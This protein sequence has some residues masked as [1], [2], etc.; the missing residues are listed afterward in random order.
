MKSSKKFMMRVLTAALAL[1]MVAGTGI[2]AAAADEEPIDGEPVVIAPVDD[3]TP[4]YQTKLEALKTM[5]SEA[6]Q[7]AYAK[8]SQTTL[9]RLMVVSQKVKA[10]DEIIAKAAYQETEIRNNVSMQVAQ[11]Q[12]EAE[13]LIAS[14]DYDEDFEAQIMATVE[15]KIAQIVED[16]EAQIE[17]IVTEAGEASGILLEEASTELEEIRA[18]LQ[19]KA[20][21]AAEALQAKVDAMQQQIAAVKE[22]AEAAVQQAKEALDQTAI[23]KL[24]KAALKTKMAEKIMAEAELKDSQIKNAVAMQV[25]QIN[26][27]TDALV[28]ALGDDEELINSIQEQIQQK[29]EKLIEDA[30]AE[31]DQVWAEAEEQAAALLAEAEE[32]NAE[33]KAQ[34][35]EEVAAV[36]EMLAQKAA[37]VQAEVDALK[38]QMA[39]KAAE[40]KAEVSQFVSDVLELINQKT[41][42]VSQVEEGEF[43]YIVFTNKLFGTAYAVVY[44]YTGEDEE[45]TIPAYVGDVPVTRMAITKETAMKTV[46]VPATV[47]EI[48]GLSFVSCNKLEAINVDEDNEY[49]QSIDGVVFSKDGLVVYAVPQ[50]KEFNAS[51]GVVTVAEYAYFGSQMEEIVL[52]STVDTI[53]DGAFMNCENLTKLEISPDVTYIGENAF[54]SAAEGFTIYCYEDSYAQQYAE[55]NGINYE[56]IEEE[57]ELSV[58]VDIVYD[59]ENAYE[60]GVMALGTTVHFTA[61]GEGG[62]GDY[63]YACYYKKADS[64]TWT[65]RQGF[66][67]ASD[68]GEISLTP[69][70]AGVYD[71]CVKVKDSAGTVEKAIFQIEVAGKEEEE[72]GSRISKSKIELGEQITA[73]AVAE[74][75]M[76][77]CT[78]AFYYKKTDAEKWSCRQKFS[79]A[80]T[81]TITPVEAGEYQICIKIKDENNQV[82]KKY[83]TLTVNDVELYP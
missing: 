38:A 74:E 1:S 64:D 25:A 67:I 60:T 35:Q 82:S 81:T 17:Q 59:D 55:E 31:I 29:V 76:E 50:A 65:A 15:A 47:E 27:D 39:A 41:T 56:L 33:A 75:G 20:T 51:E 19:E 2:G 13:A 18:E 83:F 32:L 9:A 72:T 10:A 30:L 68:N 26:A 16:A 58:G 37:E 23:V 80:D 49:Y 40:V 66:K 14:A 77:N 22:Q 52:P 61:E 73:Y 54:A 36:K 8:L 78:Y 71:I 45:V 48:D 7:S 62:A 70:E 34:I 6:A 44:E 28:A 3:E 24:V 63:I 53:G 57:E 5:L 4:D 11:I 42:K 69:T 21:K 43:K 46:N 79:E 12:K